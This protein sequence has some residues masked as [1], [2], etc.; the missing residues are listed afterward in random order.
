VRSMSR[1]T[2]LLSAAV[3]V[4]VVVAL[5]LVRYKYRPQQADEPAIRAALETYLT[6]RSGL[7]LS[8]MDVIIK[9]VKTE[10]DHAEAQVEFHAKQGD[11]QMQMTYDFVRQG[12]AWVVQKSSGAAGS[13]HPPIPE[14]MPP[15][16]AGALPP[17]HP[18]VHGEGNPPAAPPTKQ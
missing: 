3:V 12:N 4:V 11:A 10:G 17:G 18:P 14:G 2:I 1:K 7:N 15:A 8:G 13:G 5:V 6:Q 16:G 9:S